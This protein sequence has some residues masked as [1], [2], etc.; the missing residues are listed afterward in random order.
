MI[1]KN[2]IKRNDLMKNHLATLNLRK[3]YILTDL[4]KELKY[5]ELCNF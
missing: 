1:F 4:Q 2:K 3:L 5:K